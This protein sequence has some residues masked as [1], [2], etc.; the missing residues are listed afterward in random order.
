MSLHAIVVAIVL[1]LTVRCA[2]TRAQQCDDFDQCTASEMCSQGE[3]VGTPISGGLCDDGNACTANDSCIHGSCAGTPVADDT[4]CRD[5]CGTCISGNCIPN[6]AMNNSPCDD[7]ILCTTNDRCQF[8]VCLGDLRQCPDS[9]G[10]PCTL[11]FCNPV[12]GN[13]QATNFPP[14]LPCQTCRVTGGATFACDNRTNGVSCDDFNECTGDGTCMDGEC[15][16]GSPITPGAS[17]PTA[18]VTPIATSTPLLPTFTPTVSLATMTP[19]ELPTVT[20]GPATPT[21][22]TT[23][24]IV[25][26]TLT[27]TQES[28]P[29]NPTATSFQATPTA[30]VP[31]VGDCDGDGTVTVDEIVTAVNIALG[32][33]SIDDCPAADANGDNEVTVDEIIRA[34]NNAL[35]GCG[36]A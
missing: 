13:C 28:T 21:A 16:A 17:T 36:H 30:G 5:G 10:N 4:P 34:V 23:E 27:P 15:Q 24:T 6:F 20:I 33:R 11:D 8:G 14:C 35:L 2:P 7:G 19:T 3:C 9:D 26:A 22:A 18:T 32:S 12:T 29:P 1:L 31:C 25:P